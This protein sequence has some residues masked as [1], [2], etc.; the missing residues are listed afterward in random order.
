MTTEND[1]CCDL[2]YTGQLEVVVYALRQRQAELCEFPTSQSYTVRLY[3]KKIYMAG[4]DLVH[5]CPVTAQLNGGAPLCEILT[6]ERF[7]PGRTYR[8]TNNSI[9]PQQ[10]LWQRPHRGDLLEKD[11][12]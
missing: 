12:C 9:P 1:T 5:E 2:R 8:G 6:L 10:E 7:L 11:K 3:L 4:Q